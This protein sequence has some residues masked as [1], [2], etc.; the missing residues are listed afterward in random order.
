MRRN[1]C[2]CDNDNFAVRNASGWGGAARAQLLLPLRP[3]AL[4]LLPRRFVLPA[5]LPAAGPPAKTKTGKGMRRRTFG[6]QKPSLPSKGKR[7]RIKRAMEQI[8]QQVAMDPSLFR[9]GDL[10]LPP[11][12]DR[13][14][15]AREYMMKRL[16]RVAADANR[17][18]A[19]SGG[20]G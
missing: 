2:D 10:R 14:P 8:E 6:K 13:I 5:L 7:E 11:I 16:A 17:R 20:V 3:L 19:P 12:A 1:P 15:G 4:Q 18:A 9:S